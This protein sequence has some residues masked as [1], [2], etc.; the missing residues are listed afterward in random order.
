MLL[1]EEGIAGADTFDKDREALIKNRE[2]YE[3]IFSTQDASVSKFYDVKYVLSSEPDSGNQIKLY[4]TV[5][6]TDEAEIFR[7][8]HALPSSS[9]INQE[10]KELLDGY[11]NLPEEQKISKQQ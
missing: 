2:L 9:P 3:Q 6:T 10:I 5:L 7:H 8:T 11:R 4:D 1:S